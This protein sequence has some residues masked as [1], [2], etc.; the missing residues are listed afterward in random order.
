MFRS[1]LSRRGQVPI[2]IFVVG[3]VAVCILALF[4]FLNSS[5][6]VG[7]SFVGIHVTKD[8]NAQIEAYRFYQSVGED[9]A[10]YLDIRSDRDGGRYLFSYRNGVLV[11]YYLS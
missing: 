11:K 5:S 2:V 3:V 4:S 6:R 9:P 10:L 7:D 8:L 1:N